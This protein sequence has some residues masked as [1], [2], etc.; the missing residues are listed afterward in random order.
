MK[1]GGS[2]FGVNNVFAYWNVDQRSNFLYNASM[3]DI[4]AYDCVVLMNFNP[5]TEAA[6]FFGRLRQRVT[7]GK[8][9]VFEVGQFSYDSTFFSF[10]TSTDTFLALLEGRHS[11]CKKLLR[12][13]NVLVLKGTE[14]NGRSDF[15][16]WSSL[17]ECFSSTFF[18]KSQYLYYY[19]QNSATSSVNT[20]HNAA[21]EAYRLDLALVSPIFGDSL[22]TAT[23]AYLFEYDNVSL[24]S[25][26]DRKVTSIFYE[27]SHFDIGARLADG[28]F[29]SVSVFERSGIFMNTQG[30]AFVN[31]KLITEKAIFSN[32]MLSIVA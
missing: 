31:N 4:D 13:N 5:K 2:F 16:S 22:V 15:F 18:S 24:F 26:F 21:N 30:L 14:L 9:D 6:V 19:L 20:F 17:L 23:S 28:V 32:R 3:L 29:A 7:A 27:G 1:T 11:F 25:L 12:Y 8:L 10:G